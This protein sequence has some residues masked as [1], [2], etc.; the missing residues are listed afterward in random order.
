MRMREPL[1]LADDAITRVSPGAEEAAIGR[2]E[3][4]ELYAELELLPHKQREAVVLRD[5]Y[6]LRYDEVAKALGTSRAAV[7]AL[8]FRGRRRL[9]RRLR[10]GV[11][12][13][14]L[15]VPLAVQES[16]AYAVPGFA[17]TAAPAGAAATAAAVPL[18]VKL[19]AGG[20]AI[21][22]AGSAGVVA[23]RG[24]HDPPGRPA[25]AVVRPSA[26]APAESAVGAKPSVTVVRGSLVEPAATGARGS[27]SA[28]EDEP[29]RAAG[30]PPVD[31]DRD[32]R[33]GDEGN[34]GPAGG[35][36]EPEPEPERER[37]D[38][39]GPG[40]SGRSGASEEHAADEPVEVDEPDAAAEPTE[41][42][43]PDR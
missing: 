30:L 2:E 39:S 41:L 33:G 26:A 1:A 12:A 7:E 25:A 36:S 24:L 29:A 20:A 6:G 8:L 23:E 35:K 31:D 37:G 28:G 4:A 19:A 13:G 14:V 3:A 32:E 18:L 10:P 38:S 21:G 27:S 17:A 22:I 34:S 16:I 43:E 42:D 11:A 40:A 5:L 9:Q 15:V